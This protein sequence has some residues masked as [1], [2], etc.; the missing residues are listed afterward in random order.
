M[1]E[2]ILKISNFRDKV[3]VTIVDLRIFRIDKLS[4]AA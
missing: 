4:I 1:Y 2:K 3:S